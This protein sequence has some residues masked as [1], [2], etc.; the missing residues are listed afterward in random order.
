MTKVILTLNAGSSNLKYSVYDARELTQIDAGKI[1]FNKGEAHPAQYALDRVMALVENRHGSA[2]VAAVGHRVVHGG[3]RFSLPTPVSDEVMAE[4]HKLVPLAPLHLPAELDAIEVISRYYAKLPQ[5]VCF[6]TAFHATQLPLA[7]WFGLTRELM[8]AGVKR[9]GFHGLSYHYISTVLPVHLAPRQQARVVVAHLGNGASMCALRDCLSVTTTMGFTALDGLMMGTR[10]GELD[11]G[12]VLHLCQ[13]LGM[14][15]AQVQNLLYKQSGLLGVSGISSDMRDLEQS[16]A[17][18]ARE[19]RELFALR[20]AQKLASLLPALGGL[21]AIVFTGGIG[22]HSS[23]T[24][25]MICERLGWLGVQL[26][27]LANQRHATRI[28]AGA[29]SAVGVYVI[30][31]NEELMIA[32]QTADALN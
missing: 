28:D 3:D 9:Y 13:E 21:D 29:N 1:E 24:R 16:S 27:E 15:L 31:T 4:L 18:E 5:V 6:D 17:A 14:S 25:A 22:E 23:A 10:C 26:D 32:Q 19:A 30:P 12:V 11:P 20:A 7:R 8:A 2:A